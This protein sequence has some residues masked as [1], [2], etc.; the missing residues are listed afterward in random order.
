MLRRIGKWFL[1]ASIGLLF[2]TSAAHAAVLEVSDG[3]VGTGA[4]FKSYAFTI[5]T[6]GFY[7]ATLA[8]YGFPEAFTSLKL[9]IAQTAGPLVGQISNV[10]SFIFNATTTGSYT[11]LLFGTPTAEGGSYSIKV[12]AVPEPEVWAMMLIGVGLIGY[13]VR[14]KSKGGPVRIVG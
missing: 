3:L 2:L 5:G 13:Q 9:G 8:D 10:G 4:Q 11:A 1:A 12:A 7:Q 6:T 14:R